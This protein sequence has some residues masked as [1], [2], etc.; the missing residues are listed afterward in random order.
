[1]G[2]YTGKKCRLLTMLWLT[3][4]FFLVE[5]VVG[6]VTNCMALIADS[7]HMLSDVV[8]LAVAFLSVKPKIRRASP[9]CQWIESYI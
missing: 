7:F 8:A 3:A 1:M 6:Y 5:I 4:L 2:R 9:P